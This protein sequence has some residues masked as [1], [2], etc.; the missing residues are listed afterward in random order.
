MNKKKY[1]I[2]QMTEIDSF[3]GMG[4]DLKI[5]YLSNCPETY[6]AYVLE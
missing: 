6:T 1:I 2:A 3:G 5:I 4:L